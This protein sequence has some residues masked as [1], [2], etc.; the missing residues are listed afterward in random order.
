MHFCEKCL[1]C[2]FSGNKIFDASDVV[3]FLITI[4]LQ[5][6]L[7]KNVSAD[8]KKSYRARL[9]FS[10]ILQLRSFNSH[11]DFYIDKC[12]SSSV[13]IN[14]DKKRNCYCAFWRTLEMHPE[15]EKSYL[16]F[17]SLYIK[18]KILICQQFIIIDLMI[19]EVMIHLSKYE[20]LVWRIVLLFHQ[21]RRESNLFQL[22][23]SI[24]RNLLCNVMHFVIFA[25]IQFIIFK[26][27][28]CIMHQ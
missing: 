9:Q 4:S 8:D 2:Y 20:N 19:F 18:T 10:F 15:Y 11:L 22:F 3:F 28:I 17:L 27:L 14:W 21:P 25:N 26:I 24:F 12:S 1:K 6:Q 13:C 7:Q 5:A 23:V 16:S